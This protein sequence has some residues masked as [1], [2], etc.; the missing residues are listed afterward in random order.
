[1]NSSRFKISLVIALGAALNGCAVGPD[2]HR[3]AVRVPAH[4][5]AQ[6]GWTPAAPADRAPKGDW[7]TDFHDPLLDRLEPLI[8][9]SNQSVRQTYA[10]YQQALALVKVA[11]AQL[12]PSF[13]LAAAVSRSRSG[14]GGAGAARAGSVVD[15][16][17]LEGIASWSPDL[18]GAVRRLVQQNAAIA[19]ADQA[20][21]ANA[22]LS[23]QTL[24]ATTVIELRIADADIGLQNKTVEAYR[25]TLR[26]TLQQQAAGVSTAPPSAVIAA[27]V[28]LETEQAN[29]ISLGVVRA[30]YAHAIAIL[31][32]R[33]P[34]DLDIP[35]DPVM[36][37]LPTVPAGVPSSLLQRR[38]DIAAAERSMAAQNAAVGYAVAAYYPSLSL[39][40]AAGFSQSPLNGLLHAA[41]DVWSLGANGAETLFDFGAR[42]AQVQ[43]A[44]AAY[45]AA[46]ASYRGTVLNAFARVENDLTGLQILALQAQA[47]DRAVRDAIRG[48][49]IAL[50]EFQAGTVDY[51][52]VA[53]AQVAQLSDQQAALAV[54]QSRLVDAVALIGDLG[55]G[56]SV[57]RLRDPLHPNGSARAAT[58]TP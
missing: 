24:L 21:L 42:H 14:S 9:T 35:Q 7:W 58:P 54:Q 26:L 41:N 38:P 52:A 39:S 36:P 43:A 4:Y 48:T 19:Q 49:E 15:S 45:Q 18:W 53:Q 8:A 5:A 12:L 55:G 47:L 46:V 57:D 2:Y 33:N 30:Q 10:N 22:T 37:T 6:P 31:V 28:A 44:R 20:L 50:A 32:G 11:R 40:A 25:K 51:T 16:G 56:W 29:R 13:G 23:V 17:S 3:P 34:E 27:R 1:M